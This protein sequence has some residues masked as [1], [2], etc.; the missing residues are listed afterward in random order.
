MSRPNLI[1]IYNALAKP[2]FY[3]KS[4]VVTLFEL[5][6]WVVSR[7]ILKRLFYYKDA[8]FFTYRLEYIISPFVIGLLVRLLS[9]G[10]CCFEDEQGATQKITL[11][12]LL[13]S[14]LLLVRDYIKKSWLV[15]K[16]FREVCNLS[17]NIG[18]CKSKLSLDLRLRPAY[19]RT[20]LWLGVRSGGSVGHIAGVLNHLGG[21]AGPPIFISTDKI[22]TVKD[23]IETHIIKPVFNYPDFKEPRLISS[24][25]T[26]E[27]NAKDI[28]HNRK[29]SFIYSRYSLDNYSAVKLAK[30]YNI[31]LIIEYNGSEVWISK[32][33]GT[34]L[35][36]QKLAEEIESLNL[37][38]ANLVVVVSKAMKKEL[39]ARGISGDKIL[40]NPNGVEPDKYSPDIDDSEVRGKYNLHNKIVIGFIGTFGKWHGAEVLAEAFGRLINKYPEYR[41]RVH[42]L[43]VGDGIKK[44]MVLENLE[45]SDVINISTL[46]GLVPQEDGPKH[47]AACDILVSPHIPNADGTPFF[48]SPTKLF[49]YM[50][51]GKGIVASNL[52][53]IGEVLEHNR[54]A[55]LVKPGDLEELIQGIKKLIDNESL[56]NN[57]GRAARDEVVAKYTW[58]EHT[59]KIVE[60]LKERCN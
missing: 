51:M 24:G 59:R 16:T 55:W 11:I 45:K 41:N 54:T 21:L 27:K 50:A 34:P 18:R 47:L 26:F 12:F 40:V 5:K 53:Q 44:P 48:G 38:S 9:R 25:V 6:E 29:L 15:R 58:K 17:F 30:Y 23:D 42:L 56:R 52:D 35:K 20:D 43:M 4:Q 13:K 19:I 57:F 37:N 60:A 32:N 1:I 22:P 49:E 14:L 39:T 33:W 8:R 7:S 10:V 28:L 31:P 3:P 36:Y 2:E 46:T